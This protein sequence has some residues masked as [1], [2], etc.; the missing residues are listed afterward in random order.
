MLYIKTFKGYE[1]RIID[2]DNEV[3]AWILAQGNGIEVVDVKIALAHEHESN[4]GMGDLIYVL[5]YRADLPAP[6]LAPAPMPTGY[7]T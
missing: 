3:N 4:S 2:L 7:E 1:D 5:L 6:E